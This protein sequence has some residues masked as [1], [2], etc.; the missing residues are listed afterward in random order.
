MSVVVIN[1]VEGYDGAERGCMQLANDCNGHYLPAEWGMYPSSHLTS[2]QT[3]GN[4]SDTFSQHLLHTL[5]SL[6]TEK[7]LNPHKAERTPLSPNRSARGRSFTTWT[8]SSLT[9]ALAM[10]YCY[11]C[12][13]LRSFHASIFYDRPK[14]VPH[15]DLKWIAIEDMEIVD[16]NKAA[17]TEKARDVMLQRQSGSPGISRHART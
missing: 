10:M 2:L 6:C 8:N 4:W 9:H 11:C 13:L 12:L 16:K 1:A 7:H 15:A 17:D 5:H 14:C 3:H